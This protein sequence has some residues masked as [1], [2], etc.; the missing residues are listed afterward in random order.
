MKSRVYLYVYKTQLIRSFNYK[1]EVYGNIL[2]QT[3]IMLANAFFW[4]ALFK[5]T[6]TIKGVDVDTMLTYTVVSSLISV[7]LTTTVE[8][9]IQESVRKGSVAIDYL[10]PINIY[11]VYFSENMASVTGLVFQNL[12][13]IFIIGSLLIKMPHPKDLS[14]LILFII[15][16]GLAFVLNWLIAVSFGMWSFWVL[17]IDAL[18]QAKKHLIRLLSGSLIP[19]WFFPEWLRNTLQCLPFMYLYQLPLNIFIGKAGKR[20]IIQGFAVQI[21]WIVIMFVFYNW[22][23]TRVKHKIVVQG[24]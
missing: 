3:I 10:R 23:K 21:V 17:E 2:I 14:S 12:I 11:K 9:R 16:L 19:I 8:R 15:C 7:V 18:L 20:E 4:R 1:F 5:N 6:E 24:G 13:P 22:L